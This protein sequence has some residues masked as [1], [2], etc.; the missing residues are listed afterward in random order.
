MLRVV[1]SGGRIGLANWTPDGMIGQLFRLIGSFVPP[2]AGVASPAA[3]GAETRLVELF[4]PAARDIHTERKQYA[5]RFRSAEH[6]IEVFR[7][8]YGPVNKA[9]AALDA[10]KQEALHQGLLEL[11]GRF[12]RGGRETLIAPSDYLEV[13]VTKD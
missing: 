6:W 11:L 12:N 10:A 5:F 9:F 13:V 1:R 7:R 2:P 8:Y 4:G 3:W